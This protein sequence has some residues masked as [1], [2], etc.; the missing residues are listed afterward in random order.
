MLYVLYHCCQH[1]TLSQ[2]PV[3]TLSSSSRCG[4]CAPWCPLV[5]VPLGTMNSKCSTWTP[6]P[7]RP[8]SH[9]L[10]KWAKPETWELLFSPRL[11]GSNWLLRRMELSYFI[12]TIS[13]ALL[14]LPS[15]GHWNSPLA[16][17]YGVFQQGWVVSFKSPRI[18]VCE[19]L[20]S[21]GAEKAVWT[22][23]DCNVHK[24]GVKP[25]LSGCP[26]LQF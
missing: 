4:A 17:E 15:C 3:S 14:D 11:P 18:D 20:Y 24:L 25:W 26:F 13:L 22:W 21:S 8:S 5:T 1:L 23:P 16:T 2:S 7:L 12:A 19:T 9:H 6:F 10:G